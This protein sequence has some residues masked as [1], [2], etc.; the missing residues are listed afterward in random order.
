MLDPSDKVKIC[1]FPAVYVDFC[2]ELPLY[3]KNLVQ[4]LTSKGGDEVQSERPAF[5]A[6]FARFVS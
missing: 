3:C 6:K 1:A 2:I 4:L 5:F